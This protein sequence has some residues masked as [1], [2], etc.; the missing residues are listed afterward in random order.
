MDN[1]YLNKNVLPALT[2][3]FTAMAVQCPDDKVEFIGR[4]LLAYVDRK[5]KMQSKTAEINELERNL[6]SYLAEEAQR[7]HEMETQKEPI[8]WKTKQYEM[9]LSKID[10][11]STKQAGMDAVAEFLEGPLEIPAAYIALRYTSGETVDMLKYLSKGK[12]DPIVLGKKLMKP[13]TD[14]GEDAPERQGVSFEAFKVPEVPESDEPPPDDGQET[15]AKG[16]PALLPLVINN[17]MRDKRVKFFGI[18]KLGAYVAIPFTYASIDHEAAVVYTPAEGDNPASFA[19]VRKDCQFLIG[20]DTIGVYRLF[21][22][23]EI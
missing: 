23:E 17:V 16:P 22:N 9:F 5:I 13:A 21:T 2:E 6:N 11:H 18:P 10:S 1:A 20:C 15:V 4:Y 7:Q 14:E 12:N 3:A 8:V 19:L